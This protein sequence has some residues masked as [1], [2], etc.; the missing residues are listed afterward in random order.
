[1]WGWDTN[2]NRRMERSTIAQPD[3]TVNTHRDRLQPN[4]S[5]PVMTL[6][7]SIA[8]RPQEGRWASLSVR[9]LGLP[10]SAEFL[11]K[12]PILLLRNLARHSLIRSEGSYRMGD[13]IVQ[14]AEQIVLD[15]FAR[16]LPELNRPNHAPPESDP[17]GHW[18][19]RQS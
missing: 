9:E 6:N 12:G 1:M 14:E 13:P 2:N 19:I 16:Y 15:M 3:G 7:G 11:Q 4:A 17:Q 10:S 18:S 5:V 8:Y